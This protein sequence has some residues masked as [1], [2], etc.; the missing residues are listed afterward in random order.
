M[1]K[2]KKLLSKQAKILL[3]KRKM[4]KTRFGRIEVTSLTAQEVLK[5]Y[6]DTGLTYQ[7]VVWHADSAT[8]FMINK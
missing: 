3:V 2:G 5:L 6:S 1:Q 7:L 8:Y 4:L